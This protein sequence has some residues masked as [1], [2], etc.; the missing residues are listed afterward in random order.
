M[1]PFPNKRSQKAV[2]LVIGLTGLITIAA[3]LNSNQVPQLFGID[4][5]II[6][7]ILF[8]LGAIYIVQATSDGREG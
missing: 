7:V 4:Y 1:W 2:S 3:T 8:I 5:R 6:G